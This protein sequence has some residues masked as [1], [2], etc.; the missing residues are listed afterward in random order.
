MLQNYSAADTVA[1]TFPR[2]E[3]PKLELL[4]R[5]GS[6]V[7]LHQMQRDLCVRSVDVGGERIEVDLRDIAP[8]L[9]G[10]VPAA[11]PADRAGVL[12]FTLRHQFATAGAFLQA[13]K[14]HA[15]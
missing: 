1:P 7:W 14:E 8:Q 6:S 12:F 10:E 3:L 9:D 15:R 2:L 13:A 11:A 4:F 5:D